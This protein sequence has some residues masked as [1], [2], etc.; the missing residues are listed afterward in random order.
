MLYAPVLRQAP[1][2]PPPTAPTPAGETDRSTSLAPG[3]DPNR[4]S[5]DP[6][7]ALGDGGAGSILGLGPEDESAPAPTTRS[8]TAPGRKAPTP[9]PVIPGPE[10]RTRVMTLSDVIAARDVLAEKANVHWAKGL[11]GG[12]NKESETIVNFL[13]KNKVGAGELSIAI[14]SETAGS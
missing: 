6:Q 8:K 12:Q 11:G 5:E 3:L 2:S 4:A 10:Y 1:A 14:P 9:P 13:Y 7:S